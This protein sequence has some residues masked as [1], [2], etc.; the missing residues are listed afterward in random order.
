[1][2][3]VGSFIVLVT[4]ILNSLLPVSLAQSVTS[5][6]TPGAMVA[7]S[8]PFTP[9]ILRGLK[10]YPSNPFHLDFILDEGSILKGDTRS[11]DPVFTDDINKLVRYFLAGLT[12]PAKDLWVNLSPYEK[13]RI[14]PDIFGRTEMGRDLLEQDYLLKQVTASVLHPDNVFGKEFW[15]KVYAQEKLKFGRTDIEVD[16]FNKVWIMPAEAVVFENSDRVFVVKSTLKV[17]L[18]SDYLAIGHSVGLKAGKK[19]VPLNAM[20]ELSQKVVREIIVPVLEKEVNEGE[21]FTRL[22]QVYNSLILATWYKR[23][24]KDSLLGTVYVDR[25]KTGG[26]DIADRQMPEKIWERYVEAFKRGAFNVIKEERDEISDEL[27]PRKYF[28]GGETF[29]GLDQAMTVAPNFVRSLIGAASIFLLV[30]VG[31]APAIAVAAPPATGIVATAQAHDQDY[32]MSLA[33]EQYASVFERIGEFIDRPFAIDVLKVATSASPSLSPWNSTQM[34]VSHLSLFIHHPRSGEIIEII[35]KDQSFFLLRYNVLKAAEKD[36]AIR[37]AVAVAVAQNPNSMLYE[38][39]DKHPEMPEAELTKLLESMKSPVIQVILDVH[40]LKYE[41]SVKERMLALTQD[42]INGGLSLESAASLVQDNNKYLR[43]LLAIKDAT[44]YIENTT[45]ERALGTAASLLLQEDINVMQKSIQ[46]YSAREIYCLMVE[47]ENY[48]AIL[49]SHSKFDLF[50]QQFLQDVKIKGKGLPQWFYDEIGTSR[51]RSFMRLLA[52]KDNLNE[53]LDLMDVPVLKQIVIASSKEMAAQPALKY[54]EYDTAFG[55]AAVLLIAAMKAAEKDTTNKADYDPYLKQATQKVVD[56]VRNNDFRDFQLYRQQPAIQQ[57]IEQNLRRRSQA[58]DPSFFGDIERFVDLPYGKEVLV[59][60]L[61]IEPGYALG[62][63]NDK[64]GLLNIIGENPDRRAQIFFGIVRTPNSFD[65]KQ[66]MVLLWDDLITGNLTLEQASLLVAN[67]SSF[68]RRLRQYESVRVRRWQTSYYLTEVKRINDLH[69]ASPGASPETWFKSVENFDSIDIYSMMIYA[70]EEIF[71]STFNGLF[72][73]LLTKMKV[74]HMSGEQLLAQ[75][76]Y[77]NFRVFVAEISEFDRLNEFFA[78]MTAS[79]R[80]DLLTRFVCNLE[81]EKDPLEQAVTVADLFSVVK[82][83]AL[84]RRLQELVNQE[85]GRVAS[86]GQKEGVI[87]YGILSGMFGNKAVV[88]AEWFKMMSAKYA[89]PN[90]EKIS[91]SK[92]FNA[93]GVNIQRYYFYKDE[94]GVAS[95]E[96]FLSFYRNKAGW[97]VAFETNFVHIV[98]TSSGKRIEIFANKPDKENEGDADIATVFKQR[99]LKALI[100]THRGHSGHTPVTIEKIRPEAVIVSLGSCGGYRNI[101]SVLEHAPQAIIFLTKSIGTMYVNDLL[102]FMLNIEILRGQDIMLSDFWRKAQQRIKDRRFDYYIGPHK[103]IVAIFIWLYR[104]KIE[105]TAGTVT[106]DESM[107]LAAT[108]GIDLNT[109]EQKFQADQNIAPVKF[110]IDPVMVQEY[111]FVS[112]FVPVIF[113]VHTVSDIPEF[114]G[115]SG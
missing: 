88:N 22:R 27:I 36:T 43:S 113:D 15:K 48:M 37:A 17:M 28:S 51:G 93:Q 79:A 14:V 80:D 94:D 55:D 40:R 34:A 112:G 47:L 66:K 84:L 2:R 83:T 33:H 78:M 69:E 109:V 92:L 23:K 44:G 96:H 70:R 8:H 89:L 18:E 65:D 95:F 46:G 60:A 114:L 90:I 68:R 64:I 115:V 111:Q 100:V 7:L 106:L 3:K 67:Q 52:G 26:V 87:I 50:Y 91:S 86:A 42:I 56:L 38:L 45:V 57:A 75:V 49:Q 32:W 102:F 76:K 63:I 29:A 85:Y 101:D 108:G 82:D 35:V 110:K 41:F 1:M 105:Q 58:P 13:N 62:I 24:I 104:Q 59:D 81:K 103:N 16:T 97:K 5:L 10:F 31:L 61:G 19:A 99:D 4:F 11:A 54:H 107:S 30:N 12:F 6:P 71:T 74:E 98:S 53:L 77:N 25:Q 39:E 21:N 73:R 72:E 9:P 20:Q